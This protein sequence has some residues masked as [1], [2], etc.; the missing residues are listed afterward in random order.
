MVV[1]V[2]IKGIGS[3]L[4]PV[5]IADGVKGDGRADL[6]AAIL[7]GPGGEA[8]LW[9]RI[10]DRDPKDWLFIYV[11]MRSFLTSLSIAAFGHFWPDD[12]IYYENEVIWT[13]PKVLPVVLDKEG[14]P[15]KPQ[16]VST[17]EEVRLVELQAHIALHYPQVWFYEEIGLYLLR[18]SYPPWDFYAEILLNFFKIGELVTATRYKSKP[19]LAHIL[20]ASKDLGVMHYSDEEIRQFYEVRSRDAAHDWGKAEPVTRG[21]ALE[22]KLWAEQ[23]V[24][25]DWWK[26]G[27]RVMKGDPS[28]VVHLSDSAP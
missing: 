21:K 13:R 12:A 6:D 2:R 14:D 8:F 17:R 27:I 19:K 16:H 7:K 4:T 26:H 25:L 11:K 1:G 18:N 3:S 22:C 24:Y 15:G 5:V 23:M 10:K 28:G 9:Y 20:K